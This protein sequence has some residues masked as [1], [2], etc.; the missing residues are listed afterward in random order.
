MVIIQRMLQDTTTRH[1]A[2]SVAGNQCERSQDNG[3]QT[4]TVR[5]HPALCGVSSASE[6]AVL[7][8]A[9]F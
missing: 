8:V 9:R 6:R 5:D 3:N 1:A 4:T 2:D 7:V